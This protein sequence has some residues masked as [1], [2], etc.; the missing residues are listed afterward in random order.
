MKVLYLSI[1]G[2]MIYNILLHG[3][4]QHCPYERLHKGTLQVYRQL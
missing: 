4:I 1:E 3:E 2:I